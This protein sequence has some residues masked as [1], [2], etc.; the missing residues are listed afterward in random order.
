[1]VRIGRQFVGD[2]GPKLF[3]FQLSPLYQYRT[4]PY[5][6]MLDESEDED[7]REPPDAPP[8][9][10]G[11]FP[12][13][14]QDEILD[15]G[16]DSTKTWDRIVECGVTSLI[17]RGNAKHL[18]QDLVSQPVLDALLSIAPGSFF[19]RA[20]FDF[21]G[22]S[23]H[24][25]HLLGTHRFPKSDNNPAEIDE[26]PTVI[27]RMCS[28]AFDG[29]YDE[30]GVAFRRRK[31]AIYAFPLWLAQDDKVLEIGSSPVV[32]EGFAERWQAT[33]ISKHLRENNFEH[34][35]QFHPGHGCAG[36]ADYRWVDAD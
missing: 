5:F 32:T 12:V 21:Y 35:I 15:Q 34:D 19:S 14:L 17:W 20:A 36:S 30:S 8:M 31:D 16:F 28:P 26:R 6:R 27:G 2:L 22:G 13:R 23:A 4:A 11:H 24:T 10:L 18:E 33:A 7:F 1:M 25:Y 9:F 3:R 29:S